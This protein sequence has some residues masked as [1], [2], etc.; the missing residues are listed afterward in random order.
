V[1]LNPIRL[2]TR[3]LDFADAIVL[4]LSELTNAVAELQAQVADLQ[5]TTYPHLMTS[6][7]VEEAL[8]ISN[9]TRRQL[10]MAGELPAIQIDSRPRF[11]A[12]DVEALIDRKAAS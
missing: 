11:R 10:T 8:G 4:D 1:Q 9:T 6:R 12:A 7:Q 2:R 3:S 5:Q